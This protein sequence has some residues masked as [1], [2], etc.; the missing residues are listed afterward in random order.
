MLI[1]NLNLFEMKSFD[2][3]KLKN[4]QMFAEK[5]ENV[6][7][8]YSDGINHSYCLVRRHKEDNSVD[9]ILQV[10]TLIGEN[11]KDNFENEVADL[12]KYFN[13]IIIEEYP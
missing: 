9:V 6:I 12:A 5:C 13:A 2:I 10:K 8:V 1:I 4:Q 11:K 7:G 3:E